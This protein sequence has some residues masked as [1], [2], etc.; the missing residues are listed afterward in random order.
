MR[1]ALAL[2][3]TFALLFAASTQTSRE[4]PNRVRPIMEKL[5]KIDKANRVL[6]LLLT[7][8]QART[9]LIEIEKCRVNIRNQEKKEADRLKALEPE[10]DKVH[11]DA[12]QGIV[13]S[14]EFVKKIDDLFQQFT[15]ERQAVNLANSLILKDSLEKI[16]NAGQLRAMSKVVDQIYTES[17]RSLEGVSENEKTIYFAMD[18]LLD[19]LGYQFLV[20]LSS[21]R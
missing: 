6:P 8:E 15:S 4:D 11:Q 20:E 2:V 18:I 14:Q 21:G 1:L 19:D 7:K 17:G 3:V 10:I 16:L 12:T 13:P 9:L 5:A